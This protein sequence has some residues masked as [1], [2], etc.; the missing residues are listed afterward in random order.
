MITPKVKYIGETSRSTYERLQE[1][2]WLFTNR[3]EGDPEKGEASSVL[4]HHSKEEH[5]ES[6]RKEDWKSRVMSAGL[7]ES[8]GTITD[9]GALERARTVIGRSRGDSFSLNVV[10]P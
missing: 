6:L 3:K 1:H 9:V 7:E 5:G 2:M 8:T 4:W 10:S